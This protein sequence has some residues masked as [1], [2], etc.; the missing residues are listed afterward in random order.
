ME[1]ARSMGSNGRPSGQMPDAR[2]GIKSLWIKALQPKIGPRIVSEL[3][4]DAI[5]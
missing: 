4:K 2:A 1:L 3:S 5:Q